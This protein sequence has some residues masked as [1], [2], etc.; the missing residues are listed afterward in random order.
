MKGDSWCELL[1][2]KKTCLL[3]PIVHLEGQYGLY[4]LEIK[5]S[6]SQASSKSFK[7]VGGGRELGLDLRNEK[8]VSTD[9]TTPTVRTRAEKFM[10]D[11]S[12]ISRASDSSSG[13][14]IKFRAGGKTNME[15]G[16][17]SG[18]HDLKLWIGDRGLL[19]PLCCVVD[20]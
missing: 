4:L 16:S 5:R 11:P 10:R 12:Y 18:A 6:S 8:T 2:L 9:A 19:D 3:V 1:A 7:G 17:Q 13:G 15:H 14:G 20:A